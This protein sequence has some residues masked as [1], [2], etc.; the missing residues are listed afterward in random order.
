MS[1]PLI[2]AGERSG[3]PTHIAATESGTLCAPTKSSAR[4]LNLSVRG[5]TRGAPPNRRT[6]TRNYTRARGMDRAGGATPLGVLHRGARSVPR[7]R[8][9]SPSRVSKTLKTRRK[10]AD[11]ADKDW[12]RVMRNCGREQM[13]LTPVVC[14]PGQHA[15]REAA[16]RHATLR[17]CR[18]QRLHPIPRQ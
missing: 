12:D 9:L 15:P 8:L 2:H 10:S 16:C 6:T 11:S 4:L 14:F 7:L 17:F 1:Q 5:P 18:L 13:I 3:L